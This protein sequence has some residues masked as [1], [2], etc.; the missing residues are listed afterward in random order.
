MYIFYFLVVAYFIA[1]LKP[2]NGQVTLP[3][4]EI[5][6]TGTKPSNRWG[7]TAIYYNGNMVAFGG[8]GND[9]SYLN[10]IIKLNL[11]EKTWIEV[12][13]IGT[14]PSKRTGHTAIYYNNSIIRAPT[15]P[16]FPP[17]LGPV[18]QE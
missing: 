12:T 5:T 6:P 18:P 2:T 1:V 11:K 10:D 13:S 3:W 7:S 16:P 4:E 17:V 14:K 8:R 15:P 9:G